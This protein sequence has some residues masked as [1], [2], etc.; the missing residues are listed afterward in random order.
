M[1]HSIT[2]ES[3][4]AGI[5]TVCFAWLRAPA[6]AGESGSAS[7][8]LSSSC[9][10]MC[11]YS[12]RIPLMSLWDVPSR[13][14]PSRPRPP[15]SPLSP[16]SPLSS[17]ISRLHAKPSDLLLYSVSYGSNYAHYLSVSSAWESWLWRYE[18]FWGLWILWAMYMQNPGHW[19]R[20]RLRTDFWIGALGVCL[21]FIPGDNSGKLSN[22][23]WWWP[24]YFW[25]ENVPS[26]P[27]IM[28]IKTI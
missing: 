6:S 13:S 3:D 19:V 26:K 4:S 27:Y 10:S 8:S 21:A 24:G 25:L 2:L 9:S 15:L 20:C 28:H 17:L 22:V 7:F 5:W 14:I 12:E 23:I 11:G 16:F 18:V 1:I